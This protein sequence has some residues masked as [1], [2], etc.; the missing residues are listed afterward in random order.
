MFKCASKVGA[1]ILSIAAARAEGPA[2]F[3]KGKQVTLVVGH[4]P[5]GGNDIY[6][7]MI[8]QYLRKYI[9]GNPLV[10]V[11]YMPGAGSLRAAN[12][13]YSGAP[14]DGTFIGNFGRDI[15]LLAVMGGDPAVKL[16]PTKFIWLG[17]P[18]SY[19][20]DAYML[21]VRKDAAVKTIADAEKQGGPPLNIGG[22]GEGAT[23]DDVAVLLRDTLGLN[24]KIIP[25][26]PDSNSVSL[27]VE[28]GEV[29]GHFLGLTATNA[30]RPDWLK[31]D[32]DVHALL[33]FAR[34][35]RHPLFPDVPTA[36]ELAKTDHA[37]A[38]IELA[39]LPYTLSRPFVAPPGIP[40][41]RA[42]ALQD[43]FTEMQ[44]DP[45]YLADTTKLKIDISPIDGPQAS[46][47]IDRMAQTPRELLDYVR[48]LHAG[49]KG[50]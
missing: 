34:H 10:I 11:Q 7:R 20:N 43:A 2:D 18:S 30:E 1:L 3:Y 36:E 23:S 46:A 24:L 47:L 39:E 5:G 38:L 35:T 29:D 19:A 28:Q 6:S 13:L 9:P 40:A 25:G 31:P 8:A 17:S 4:G 44:K 32:S 37:R 15:L 45:Q 27:A 41:D 33:Q 16:D 49:S 48:K 21:W 50:D 12:Y 14:K 26:Y 42:K 22:N